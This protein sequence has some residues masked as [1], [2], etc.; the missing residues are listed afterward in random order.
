MV[1]E[2]SY[3][4]ALKIKMINKIFPKNKD[5]SCNS[6]TKNVRASGLRMEEIGGWGW[7]GKL[8]VMPSE[9]NNLH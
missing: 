5:F 4:L 9:N 3:V 6:A 1:C 2:W 7:L 8:G